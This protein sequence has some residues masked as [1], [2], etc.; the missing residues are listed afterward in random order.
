MP[1]HTTAAWTLWSW[2]SNAKR[3][4]VAGMFEVE[5]LVGILVGILMEIL[6]EILVGI[7]VEILVGILLGILVEYYIC[8]CQ[9]VI[10]CIVL[11]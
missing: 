6:V 4:F 9:K 2:P 5:I 11:M 10:C 8:I 1:C 7:L 3:S